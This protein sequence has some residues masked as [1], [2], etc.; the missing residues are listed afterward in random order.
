MN[1]KAPDCRFLGGNTYLIGSTITVKVAD[2][3]VT[4]ARQTGANITFVENAA[5]LDGVGGIGATLRY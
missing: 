3:L 2:E 4:R 5:L 1:Y